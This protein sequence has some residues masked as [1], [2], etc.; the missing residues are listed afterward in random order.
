MDRAQYSWGLV[1]VVLSILG[2]T[3]CVLDILFPH[4][5]PAHHQLSRNLLD[6]GIA[7]LLGLYGVGNIREAR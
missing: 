3:L 2:A 6:L 4:A 1:C 5:L 7:A